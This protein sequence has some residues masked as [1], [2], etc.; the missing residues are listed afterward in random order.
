MNRGKSQFYQNYARYSAACAKLSDL[1][2]LTG[3]RKTYAFGLTRKL[4][5]LFSLKLT[6]YL[7]RKLSKRK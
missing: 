6:S 7:N 1:N 3:Q 4:F 5:R 2:G